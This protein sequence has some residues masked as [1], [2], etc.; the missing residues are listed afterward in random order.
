MVAA[1]TGGGAEAG[2]GIGCSV[3]RRS[4]VQAVGGFIG[5]AA[6]GGALWGSIGRRARP[7]WGGAAGRCGGL[8]ALRRRV[9][10]AIV[11]FARRVPCC[12]SAQQ[13]QHRGGRG[14]RRGAGRGLSGEERRGGRADDD[15]AAGQPGGCRHAGE[16]RMLRGQSLLPAPGRRVGP[17]R[18]AA[19]GRAPSAAGEEARRGGTRR[20][21]SRAPWPGGRRQEGDPEGAQAAAELPGTLPCGGAA[22]ARYAPGGTGG[23]VREGGKEAPGAAV[24]GAGPAARRWVAEGSALHGPLGSR[25]VA[26]SQ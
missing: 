12:G 1:G 3:T 11:A 15:G 20:E 21:E 25:G 8:R 26:V 24:P 13:R 23:R 2:A 22:A 16:L 9:G 7:G 19:R 14:G 18:R 10:W 17:V 6:G 4:R 5:G